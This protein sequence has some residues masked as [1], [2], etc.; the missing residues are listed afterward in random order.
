MVAVAFGWVEE[1][2]I[3]SLGLSLAVLAA[4]GHALAQNGQRSPLP[5]A[6]GLAEITERGRMLAGYDAAAWHSTDAVKAAGA[7]EAGLGRYVAKK[8]DSKWYVAYGKLNDS[9]DKFLIAYLATEGQTPDQFSV[10]KF[11]PPR[12]DDEF[13]LLGAKAIETA[14]AAFSGEK[15]PYNVAVIPANE[16]KWYAYVYPA[17][18]EADVYLVGVDVR[19]LISKDATTI[20]QARQLHKSVLEFKDPAKSEAAKDG[21]QATMGIHNHILDDVPEDTDVFFAMTKRPAVP[22]LIV[23]WEYTYLVLNDGTIKYQGESAKLWG[24][25]KK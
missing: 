21:H 6:A 18:T 19:Y 25:K 13:Y 3:R 2:M 10:E 22:E 11:D 7:S 8:M 4:A 23:T 24:N 12:S 17:R 14:L 16:G 5:T 15:R 9:K 1:T 20:E